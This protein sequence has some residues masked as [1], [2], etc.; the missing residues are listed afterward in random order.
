MRN[1][2]NPIPQDDSEAARDEIKARFTLL[3]QISV[4]LLPLAGVMSSFMG[5]DAGPLFMRAASWSVAGWICTAP[6]FAKL[7]IHVRAR[8]LRSPLPTT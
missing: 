2:L 4:A 8:R 6:L 7:L 3:Q 5:H 1:F